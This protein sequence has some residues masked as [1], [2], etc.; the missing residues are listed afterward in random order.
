VTPDA[1][2]YRYAP[3]RSGETAKEVLGESTGRL[4]VDQYTGHFFT[5]RLFV[6]WVETSSPTT[7]R[8]D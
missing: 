6:G 7:R 4:V 8:A 3:S 1:I 5:P 2:V